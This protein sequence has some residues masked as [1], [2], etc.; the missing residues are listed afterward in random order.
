[1]LF[2]ATNVEAYERSQIYSTGLLELEQ[3]GLIQCDFKNEYVFLKKKILRYGN[4][5]LEV[6]GDPQN[7]SKIYAGNVR[8]TF[9]GRN[10][11]KVVGDSYKGYNS[12]ILDFIITKFRRRNC[13][14]V[15]NNRLM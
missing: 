13:S 5:V 11:Y 3:L 6:Y 9:D 12:E 10:L 15:V 1:M 4:K 2:V 14:I 8:F 7:E